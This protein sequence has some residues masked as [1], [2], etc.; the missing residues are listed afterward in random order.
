MVATS[1]QADELSDECVQSMQNVY[2]FYYHEIIPKDSVSEKLSSDESLKMAAVVNKLKTD[3]PA[4]L[5]AKM[6]QHLQ[7]DNLQG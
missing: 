3:C 2:K 4:E 6:N 7:E 1:L 5:V